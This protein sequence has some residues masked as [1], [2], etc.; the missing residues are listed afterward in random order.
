MR[1]KSLR[2]QPTSWHAEDIGILC[3]LDLGSELSLPV[4]LHLSKEWV[5]ASD[6]E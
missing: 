2:G 5:G 1:F 6:V 3:I 4:H